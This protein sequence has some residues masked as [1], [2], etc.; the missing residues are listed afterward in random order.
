MNHA[1]LVTIDGVQ[2]EVLWRRVRGGWLDYAIRCQATL[3][4]HRAATA[5]ANPSHRDELA[6]ARN[7]GFEQVLLIDPW[8]R[9]SANAPTIFDSEGGLLAAVLDRDAMRPGVCLV[10]PRV[11][12]SEAGGNARTLPLDPRFNVYWSSERRQK[13][14]FLL[15]FP[16][17]S[18]TD[19]C[20]GRALDEAYFLNFAGAEADLATEPRS[21][22]PR[23]GRVEP[24]PSASRPPVRSVALFLYNRPDL[25]LKVFEAIRAARPAR[26][27]LLAD[28]PNQS[29]PGDLALC[30]Q[31][32]E[33]LDV[34]W[35]CEVFR[36]LSS[37][38]L[39][40]RLRVETGFRL[41]FD[42]VEEAILLEDDIVP[43]PD[44]FWFCEELLERHRNDERVLSIGGSAIHFGL[45]ETGGS[46]AFSRYP[47]SCGWATW[48][49]AIERYDPI[50]R[51]PE[52][53]PDALSWLRHH[54][55]NPQAAAYWAYLF[56]PAPPRRLTWD[57]VWARTGFLV[58][59]LHAVPMRNLVS[60]IGFRPDATH[61]RNPSAFSNLSTEA[62]EFPLVRAPLEHCIELDA[63]LEETVYS[64]NLIRAMARV[65]QGV[66]KHRSAR[67][68]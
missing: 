59:G 9:V 24:L 3:V 33:C 39:G 23:A 49:R 34:D 20:V 54:L 64:G 44:F 55:A 13:F 58:D 60:N 61:T 17:H 26:L 40:Q 53:F 65:R 63:F 21:G 56:E 30:Q 7:R 12:E 27:F 42:R 29:R 10:S 36:D 38:H 15:S 25:T 4:E 5:E 67:A 50:R 1:I 6:I 19:R 45:L 11:P 62:M 41:V 18:Y 46:Y 31:A 48:K 66:G 47:T 35:E 43:S 28:G 22:R 37:E 52:R 16:G 57:F 2:G 14:P 8:I 51:H 68:K 32:R